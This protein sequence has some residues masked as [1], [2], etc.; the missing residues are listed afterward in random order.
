MKGKKYIM[1]YGERK[2]ASLFVILPIIIASV[3]NGNKIQDAI[4]SSEKMIEIY[5]KDKYDNYLESL[6]KKHRKKVKE[7]GEELMQQVDSLVDESTEK[8]LESQ[9]WFDSML[10]LQDGSNTG[11]LINTKI[12]DLNKSSLKYANILNFMK[13]NFTD[14]QI[15][16]LTAVCIREQDHNLEAIAAEASLMANIFEIYEKNKEK[17]EGMTDEE[18]FYSFI[19]DGLWFNNSNDD[20]HT[21]ELMDTY[22]SRVLIKSNGES[23]I[24]ERDCTPSKEEIEV[25]KNVLVNGKRTLPG[26]I[27]EHDD[28]IVNIDHIELDGEKYYDV[29]N[30][31]LWIPYESKFV[32]KNIKD[33][34]TWTYYC[35]FENSDPFGYTSEEKR[36]EIGDGYYD[37]ETGKPMNVEITK[38]QKEQYII[39]FLRN[40]IMYNEKKYEGFK[41]VQIAAIMGNMQRECNLDETEQTDEY[42]GLIQ[43]NNARSKK[44]KEYAE[45]KGTTWEDLD[46]QLEY[47]FI[48]FYDHP[49]TWASGKK[50]QKEFLNEQDVRIATSRFLVETEMGKK[51]TGQSEE[52]IKAMFESWDIEG[53]WN[54]AEKYYEDMT[55]TRQDDIEVSR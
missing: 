47:L 30:T 17:Y 37:F 52:E 11:K 46:T 16:S 2:K 29:G 53:G 3:A 43:W 14:E 44:L 35:R 1:K 15:K 51:Y 5:A 34:G 6:N 13:Y 45:S 31:D 42:I 54:A 40:G 18:A 41:D 20:Y 10:N 55:N 8:I 12:E 36:R 49:E 7:A 23:K 50:A 19:R 9:E 28:I 39:E 27:D 32:Q 4:K 25:V 33:G 24:E 22:I 21:S 48:E 26:Y 38:E